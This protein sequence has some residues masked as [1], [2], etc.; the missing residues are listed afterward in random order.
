MY[1]DRNINEPI[2]LAAKMQAQFSNSP[3]HYYL[4]GYSGNNNIENL[5]YPNVPSKGFHYC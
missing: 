4:F 5:I 2:Q 3:V 1:S